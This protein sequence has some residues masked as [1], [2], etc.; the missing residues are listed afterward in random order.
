MQHQSLLLR[1]LHP[2]TSFSHCR[3]TH[4]HPSATAASPS[5][6]SSSYPSNATHPPVAL[7]ILGHQLA[8]EAVHERASS[9]LMVAA[10]Q[11]CRL[12]RRQLPGRQQHQRLQPPAAATKASSQQKQPVN[13]VAWQQCQQRGTQLNSGRSVETAAPNL[14]HN[15]TGHAPCA[16]VH[17]VAVEDQHIGGRGRAHDL[18]PAAQTG[19]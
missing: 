17:K 7:A 18:Q 11:E 12:W 15:H 1:K 19:T 2:A 13:R 4:Q 5:N 3:F 10:Q 6:G 14:T 9:A 16:A 8:L